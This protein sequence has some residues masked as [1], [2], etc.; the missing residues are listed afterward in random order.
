MRIQAEGRATSSLAYRPYASSPEI[1]FI[2]TVRQPLEEVGYTHASSVMP[3][4]RS[5]DA[6]SGMSTRSLT[7]SN[8]NAL[9]T[10]PAVVQVA[11]AIVP[12]LL[13]PER[14]AVAVPVF[15]SKE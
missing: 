4:V 15:S 3:F 2:T 7:P 12:L 6:E 11:P 5:S 10:L 13:R 1:S 8:D 9:P 14:S